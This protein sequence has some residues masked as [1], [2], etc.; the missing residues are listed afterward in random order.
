MALSFDYRGWNDSDGVVVASHQD[1]RDVQER[2][3]GLGKKELSEAGPMTTKVKVIRE[4][5]GT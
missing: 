3:R 5:V 2:F 4:T 1:C